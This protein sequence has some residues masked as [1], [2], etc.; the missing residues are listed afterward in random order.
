MDIAVK[1]LDLDEVSVNFFLSLFAGIRPSISPKMN[2]M[3]QEQSPL[4]FQPGDPITGEERET[5]MRISG[6]DRNKQSEKPK[7]P[8]STTSS[9][10][11]EH[12]LSNPDN[13]QVIY[14]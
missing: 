1:H 5:F 7:R 4:P 10:Y 3:E 13:D 2:F 11:A 6:E 9:V 8:Y 12:T 14:W